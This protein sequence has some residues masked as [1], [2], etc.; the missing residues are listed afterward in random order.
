MQSLPRC[1]TNVRNILSPSEERRTLAV[2]WI[3]YN[4]TESVART[5]KHADHYSTLLIKQE[6][7]INRFPIFLFSSRTNNVYV[8]SKQNNQ[9]QKHLIASLDRTFFDHVREHEEFVYE[10]SAEGKSRQD[11]KTFHF[12]IINIFLLGRLFIV[13]TTEYLN[14]RKS[15]RCYLYLKT[16]NNSETIFEKL[17]FN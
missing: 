16:K 8:L 3:Q 2:A 10:D 7:C 4:C 1:F 12:S 5:I 6:K 15:F 14:K 17:I 13:K 11:K 9:T